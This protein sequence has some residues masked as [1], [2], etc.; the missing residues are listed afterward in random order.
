MGELSR[1]GLE[2]SFGRRSYLLSINIFFFFW[3]ESPPGDL[4]RGEV[5]LGFRVIHF[6]VPGIHLNYFLFSSHDFI[7]LLY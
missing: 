4:G 6:T 5:V 1:E 3:E 7:R 2:D